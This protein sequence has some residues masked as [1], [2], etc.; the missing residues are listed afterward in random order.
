MAVVACAPGPVETTRPTEEPETV[1]P[2]DA[3]AIA[4]AALVAYEDVW[5]AVAS[6]A[7]EDPDRFAAVATGDELEELETA[8]STWRN[9]RVAWEGRRVDVVQ[10][11]EFD[12]DD[13]IVTYCNDTTE[14]RPY[15]LDGGDVSFEPGKILFYATLVE[16][17]GAWL[18]SSNGAGGELLRRGRVR[19]GGDLHSIVRM[20]ERRDSDRRP[21]RKV[22]RVAE[23]LLLDLN[24]PRHLR[25]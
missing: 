2:A 22:A 20:V 4:E 11:A 3:T 13:V 5:L 18:V 10:S 15:S 7:G 24:E 9:T 19:T 12:G 25:R 8:A 1:E 23:I 16:V 14:G 6:D 17:D 21:C